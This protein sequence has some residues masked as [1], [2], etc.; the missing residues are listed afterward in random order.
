MNSESWIAVV[1]VL[2]TLA[3]TGLGYFAQAMLSK[4]DRNWAI[5]TEKRTVRRQLLSNRLEVVEEAANIMYF[6]LVIWESEELGEPVYCDKEGS[7][8]KKRRLE[9]IIAQAFT[10]VKATGSAELENG[11]KAISAAY[12]EVEDNGVLSSEKNVASSKGLEKVIKTIDNLKAN[13]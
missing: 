13:A 10:V 12:N 7:Y 9:E 2:G 8:Q 1:G 6:F 5:D 4:R 11:F 3:G